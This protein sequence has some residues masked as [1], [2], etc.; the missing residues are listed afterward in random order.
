MSHILGLADHFVWCFSFPSPTF[1]VKSLYF[2]IF[3]TTYVLLE[4]KHTLVT[5]NQFNAQAG[6]LKIGQLGGGLTH[7]LFRRNLN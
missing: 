6:M 4:I 3:L 1:N 2:L 7:L 5:L